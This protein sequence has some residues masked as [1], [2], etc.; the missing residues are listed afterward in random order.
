M[1][2]KSKHVQVKEEEEESPLPAHIEDQRTRVTVG[3]KV[4]TNVRF[5]VSRSVVYTMRCISG[6]W[7]AIQVL[8]VLRTQFRVPELTLSF[9]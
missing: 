2:R 7:V 5:L 9:P 6:L 4:P 1:P 3:Q 8:K